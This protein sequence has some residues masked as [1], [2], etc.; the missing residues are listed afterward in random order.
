MDALPLA[1]K[2]VLVVGHIQLTC[3]NLQLSLKHVLGKYITDH[4]KNHRLCQWF[5]CCLQLCYEK[6][7]STVSNILI[8]A[9]LSRHV[10]GGNAI[11]RQR[12]SKMPT[13]FHPCCAA[14]FGIT[15][16]VLP[17]EVRTTPWRP[18]MISFGDAQCLSSL[19]S[20]I[21]ERVNWVTAVTR[22][23]KFFITTGNVFSNG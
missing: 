21:W 22:C 23:T 1:K 10:P 19:I 15:N 8:I 5:F 14:T 16:F 6:L 12:D 18:G 4:M 20:M 11:C 2:M 17:R 9:V 7:I 3:K 13:A